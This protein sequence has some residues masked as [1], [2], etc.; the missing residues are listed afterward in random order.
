MKKLSLFLPILLGVTFLAGCGGGGKTL[1]IYQNKPEIDAE[2][3]AFATIFDDEFNAKTTVTSCGGSNCSLGTILN[4]AFAAGDG[5]DI[6]V[7]DGV[8]GYL[9]Y[10]DY[11]LD[12]SSEAWVSDTDVAFKYENKTYGFPVAIEGWGLAYNKA[13]INQYNALSN[14]T[15][16]I[17]VALLKNITYYRQVF[18]ALNDAKTALGIDSVV[19]M[20]GGNL[21][22]KWVT[23]HH[24]FNT[25][26]AGGLAYGDMSVTNALLA[27]T[28]ND[29][30]LGQYSDW[31]EL[32]FQ[33]ADPTVL[34]TGDY[35]AQVGKF[36]QQK[37][38]FIHQG[39]WIEPSLKTANATFERAYAPHGAF[40]TDTDGI[41]V[42]APSWYVINKQSKNITAAK[43]FLNFL[44]SSDEGHDYMVNKIGAI[45]AFKSVTIEPTAPL[46]V[47]VMNW[48]KAG[49]IYSWNQYAFSNEFR[50]GTLGPIYANFAKTAAIANG[51]QNISGAISK[52]QFTAA[53]KAAFIARTAN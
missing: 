2:L 27:G 9:E 37:A 18:T 32:L 28:V 50:D 12:V 8:N 41:F 21:D 49:K 38:V 19:S 33:Y 11:I 4:S 43:E 29:A 53:M 44:A 10:E 45:P 25:L 39:N 5:P 30:R 6:F 15:M 48:S 51:A 22:M 24:N 14:K 23:A 42:A 3:K 26:L 7:I 20:A 52:S 34:M 17:D 1:S 47:S 40:T 13:L 35:D 16:T 36:A 46:S 31:V